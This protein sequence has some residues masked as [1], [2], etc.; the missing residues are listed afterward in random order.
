MA[1]IDP[2]SPVLNE[3]SC[4]FW[5]DELTNKKILLLE[6]EKAILFLAGNKTQKYRLDTGQT[7]Q[8]VERLNLSELTELKTSLMSDIRDLELKLGIGKKGMVQVVPAF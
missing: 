7:N 3:N 6:V 1:I 2:T 4:T 8:Q 5:Q